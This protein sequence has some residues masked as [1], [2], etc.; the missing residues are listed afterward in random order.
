M[1]SWLLLAPG[2][3]LFAA[4][5]FAQATGEVAPKASNGAS[6][7]PAD[8]ERASGLS[9]VPAD[10]G[11]LADAVVSPDAGEPQPV[12][13]SLVPVDP[14]L[15]SALPQEPVADDG[16][17][18]AMHAWLRL[19]GQ[20][21]SSYVVDAAG[22]TFAP[23][24]FEPRLRV[25]P[26]LGYRDLLL[27]AEADTATG[28]VAGMPQADQVGER[29]P[30]PAFRGL[31][32]RQLSVQVKW[33]TGL[34]RVGQQTSHWGLGLLANDGAHDG[35][36]GDFGQARFGNS[37]YRAL[38]AGRP[39]FDLGGAWRAIELAAAA[40]LVVRDANAD[41]A[42]GDRAFQGIFAA[43]FV[44]SDERWLGLYAVVRSQRP[45]GLS[46]GSRATDVVALDLSGQFERHGKGKR[47]RSWSVGF[48]LAGVWGTT[49]VG[50]TEQHP[51]L[52]VRQLGAAVKGKLQLGRTGLLLDLG[53][54]TGDQNPSDGRVDAFRMDKD[55]KAGLV[56]FDEVLGWQ[57]ARAA[58]RAADPSLAGVP[59]DGV[60]QLPSGGAVSGAWY[61]FPRVRHQARE[62]L[63][64]YGGPLFAFTT[65][66]LTDPY[67]T[68]VS[69]GGAPLN[70]LG[71]RPGRF[72]GTEFDV[73]ARGHWQL[74]EV[75]KLTGVFEAGVLLPGDAFRTAGGGVMG[76]VVVGRLRLEAEL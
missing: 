74:S 65:A 14:A 3:W 59:P 19:S 13:T 70:F 44:A 23:M 68:R 6:D 46:D 52:D 34:F 16:L 18:P 10:A 21:S 69:G 38:L 40:D 15:R 64:V 22:T 60:G 48:E 72:L 76:S 63:D 30:H 62:W 55:F 66:T 5:A 42:L 45:E 58:A 20:A 75:V 57:S 17:R 47:L 56:L 73:G 9:E 1:R 43:R 50:R 4:P 28:A 54:A 71:G 2:L 26:E 53:L 36:P 49:T 39:L 37:S 33:K 11:T 7:A 32:L 29:T 25:R 67:N 31:E 61:L 24:P 41:F 27:V 12:A 51:T 8:L 35:A